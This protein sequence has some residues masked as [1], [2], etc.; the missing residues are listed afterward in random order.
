MTE[1]WTERD[2]GPAALDAR[3]E[4]SAAQVVAYVRVGGVDEAG[5]DGLLRSTEGKHQIVERMN[6]AVKERQI[7]I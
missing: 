6:R 2:A 4:R 1:R 7:G 5:D 3:F